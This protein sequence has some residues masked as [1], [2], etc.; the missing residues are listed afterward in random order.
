MRLA[1]FDV[2]C[3]SLYTLHLGGISDVGLV[4]PW[5]KP[6]FYVLLPPSIAKNLQSRRITVFV[7]KH[8]RSRKSTSRLIVGG[9]RFAR[10]VA[11]SFARD[12]LFENNLRE[13]GSRRLGQ[14]RQANEARGP[15]GPKN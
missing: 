7:G 2:I 10:N 4:S 8:K 9:R 13:A 6:S 15:V 14:S 11:M 12:W 3:D 1:K 5:L